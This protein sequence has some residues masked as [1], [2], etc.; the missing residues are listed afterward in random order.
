MV[1]QKP[2]IMKMFEIKSVKE[3]F[4]SNKTFFLEEFIDCK[5]GQF[6]MVWL[7][8]VDEK[9]FSLMNI[10][11][12]SAI[13]LEV[14]GKWSKELFAKKQGEKI[15]L[16]GPFGKGFETNGIKRACIVGGGVGT[17]PLMGLLEE[18]KKNGA[19]TTFVLGARSKNRLL[20]EKKIK[21]TADELVVCT[22]DGTAGKKGFVTDALKELFGK[23]KFDCVFTCGPEMMMYNVFK[24]CEKEKIQVQASLERFM[25]CGFGVCAACMVD[26]VILCADGPVLFS[27][28]LSRLKEFG[29]TAYLKSG[30]RCDLKTFYE[31]KT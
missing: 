10:G 26:D 21:E 4:E 27:K 11:G 17:V 1:E 20:F 19:K 30:R 5:P 25:K 12:K 15:G 29:K 31:W 6:V 23:K 18:L 16:R 9:P 8:G 28:T 13:N 24:L 2:S 7:P 14:K 3:E 22:D